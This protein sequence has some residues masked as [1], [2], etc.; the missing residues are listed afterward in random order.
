[1]HAHLR[2]NLRVHLQSFFICQKNL[3]NP[4]S[5]TKRCPQSR[6]PQSPRNPSQ[7]SAGD[8]GGGAEQAAGARRSPAGRRRLEDCRGRRRGPPLAGNSARQWRR[9]GAGTTR[10]RRETAAAARRGDGARRLRLRPEHGDPDCFVRSP[11]TA[12][13]PAAANVLIIQKVSISREVWMSHF[14]CCPL[15]T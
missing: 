7:W 6:A 8:G 10:R 5:E 15:S 4:P 12:C 3:K 13:F 2:V 11:T 9:T 14:C 1:L